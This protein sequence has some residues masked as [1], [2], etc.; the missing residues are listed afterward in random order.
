MKIILS[1]YKKIN[2]IRVNLITQKFSRNH[3][4]CTRSL[5]ELSVEDN[6]KNNNN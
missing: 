4:S 2:K 3:K 5:A 6:T 1:L